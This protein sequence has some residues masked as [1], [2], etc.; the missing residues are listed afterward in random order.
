MAQYIYD[1]SLLSRLMRTIYTKWL[2][3]RDHDFISP[4]PLCNASR[5]DL[6]PDDLFSS[7]LDLGHINPIWAFLLPPIGVAG[8]SASQVSSAE[9]FAVA[10]YKLP[11]ARLLIGVSL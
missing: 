5:P 9:R 7:Q 8:A 11:R 4:I 3:S 10:K 1:G 2:Q 6:D